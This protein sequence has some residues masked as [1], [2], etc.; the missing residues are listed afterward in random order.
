M[1]GL[2]EKKAGPEGLSSN[3]TKK[4]DRGGKI[5]V[6]DSLDRSGVKLVDTVGG[7][8]PQKHRNSYA[9]KSSLDFLRSSAKL[10]D[11]CAKGNSIE[12]LTFYRDAEY[13]YSD[14]DSHGNS[15]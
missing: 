10:S 2:F 15:E 1:P 3:F 11:G 14:S 7:V 6:G 12:F 4:T 9:T 8:T 13:S 5:W